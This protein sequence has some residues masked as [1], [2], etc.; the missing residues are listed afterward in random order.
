MAASA[1]AATASVFSAERTVAVIARQDADLERYE[2]RPGTQ[3]VKPAPAKAA[4]GRDRRPL[5]TGRRGDRVVRRTD[6]VER[7]PRTN[8]EAV[9]VGAR[10]RVQLAAVQPDPLAH[11]DEPVP[12]FMAV[13]AARRRSMPVVRYLQL[14]PSERRRSRLRVRAR[15]RRA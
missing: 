8:L 13:V 5:G 1:T 9:P 11:P 6:A 2:Q 10:S 12:G 3:W 7:N 4:T 15:C 14:E